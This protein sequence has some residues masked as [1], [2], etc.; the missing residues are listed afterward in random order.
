MIL[1]FSISTDIPSLALRNLMAIVFEIENVYYICIAYLFL[2]TVL[3]M[4]CICI[5]YVLNNNN[6]DNIFS[7]DP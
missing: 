4:Y 7:V 6:N 1:S 3:Y 2:Y 5:V